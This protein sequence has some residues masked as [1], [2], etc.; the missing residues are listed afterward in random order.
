MFKNLAPLLWHS[1]AQFLS[2]SI[3]PTLSPP[4]V[5]LAASNRV[6]NVLTLLQQLRKRCMF[7]NLP[8]LLWHNFRATVDTFIVQKVLLDDVGLGYVCATPERFFEMGWALAN[9]L[10]LLTSHP[11][12]RLL[13]FIIRCFLRLIDN[14]RFVPS[15]LILCIT[16]ALRHKLQMFVSSPIHCRTSVPL[17]FSCLF[18]ACGVMGHSR[19]VSRLKNPTEY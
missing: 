17:I 7:K 4:N 10:I 2:Y 14:P 13:K 15:F 19:T 3:Y 18:L 8:Q 5:T 6:C 1:F 16:C 9:M 11:S 12:T